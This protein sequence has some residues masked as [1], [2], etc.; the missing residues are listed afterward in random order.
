MLVYGTVVSM[1]VLSKLYSHTLDSGRLSMTNPGGSKV[2]LLCD[3]SQ[4]WLVQELQ[5]QHTHDG[6]STM[7]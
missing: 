2:L 3:L 4:Y 6:E 1:Y 7:G 5:Q